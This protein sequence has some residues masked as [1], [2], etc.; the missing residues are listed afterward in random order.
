MKRREFLSLAGKNAIG[1]VI[2]P[3]APNEQSS[4]THW[5]ETVYEQFGA[6]PMGTDVQTKQTGDTQITRETRLWKLPPLL[7]S[8]QTD[9]FLLISRE[10]EPLDS[11]FIRSIHPP[12]EQLVLLIPHSQIDQPLIKKTDFTFNFG[13]KQIGLN[14]SVGEFG[15]EI[16]RAFIGQT[17][18]ATFNIPTESPIVNEFGFNSNQ[19]QV[20]LI[21]DFP[22]LIRNE[23]QWAL[24][25]APALIYPNVPYGNHLIPLPEEII[26]Y[27][28]AENK[29]HSVS[30]G[31]LKVVSGM[32]EKP[33]TFLSIPETNDRWTSSNSV[34]RFTRHIG[35]I[36]DKLRAVQIATLEYFPEDQS[37]LNQLLQL[38]SP[39][40]PE[41][42]RDYLP[43]KHNT[44]LYPETD[45]SI[46]S[47]F[48]AQIR[49]IIGFSRSE[50]LNW[51]DFP[52]EFKPVITLPEYQAKIEI[53]LGLNPTTGA[54]YVQ[55]TIRTLLQDNHNPDSDFELTI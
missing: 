30:Q 13:L 34:K 22:I 2:S 42:P 17:P 29:F 50:T 16:P 33:F 8:N 12:V 41:L 49:P 44:S 32:T 48:F 11:D 15:V 25:I 24:S 53:P 4:Q 7:N 55:A 45:D 52:E 23:Q 19:T 38:Y 27:G 5:P 1:A 6:E 51:P 26:N 14:Y 18:I 28:P 21:K 31:I 36:P 9:T 20:P 54:L 46:F 3:L 43:Q 35:L 40:G 10:G 37:R 47:N 39:S